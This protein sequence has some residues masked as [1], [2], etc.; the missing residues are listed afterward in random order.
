MFHDTLAV[1]FGVMLVGPAMAGKS[2]VMHTLRKSYASLHKDG[3]KDDSFTRMEYSILNPKSIS[4]DEL[5]G[6]FDPLT[7][8]WTDGLASIILRKYVQTPE[9]DKR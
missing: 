7:Q 2:S 8:T 3:V 9:D 1:R 4:M 6:L 5:Y